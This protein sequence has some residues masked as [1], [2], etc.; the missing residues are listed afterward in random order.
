MKSRKFWKDICKI[1]II[2]APSVAVAIASGQLVQWGLREYQKSKS[3]EAEIKKLHAAPL[4]GMI[5]RDNPSAVKVLKEAMAKDVDGKTVDK[6]RSQ[7]AQLAKTLAWP[8]IAAAQDEK[9]TAIWTVQHALLAHLE[10]L[11]LK[12]C[13]EFFESGIHDVNALDP[14]SKDLFNSVLEQLESGYLDGK[15]KP[16]NPTTLSQQDWAELFSALGFT[17]AEMKVLADI[18]RSDDR[19]VCRVGVKLYDS[20]LSKI[21]INQQPRMIRGIFALMSSS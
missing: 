19:E 12:L 16:A 3:I 7:A 14:S 4:I 11:D 2:V 10:K 18:N 17:E 15:G 5:L 1:V 6:S 9:V 13:R 8:S 21:A 20:M